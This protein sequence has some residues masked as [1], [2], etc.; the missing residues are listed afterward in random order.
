M[1]YR[2]DSVNEANLKFFLG[3]LFVV[4]ESC[5]NPLIVHSEWISRVDVTKLLSLL[6]LLFHI[7]SPFFFLLKSIN[8]LLIFFLVLDIFYLLLNISHSFDEI[9][10]C[11]W[12]L[13]ATMN[14]IT[15]KM[16][17]NIFE[18]NYLFIFCSQCFYSYIYKYFRFNF[19]S[20]FELFA[21]A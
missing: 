12:I 14:L 1:F 7:R 19:S 4:V 2:I 13:N 9:N 20:N 8:N 17:E 16:N 3:C 5:V 11:V 18:Y 6:L 21:F 10:V 15:V